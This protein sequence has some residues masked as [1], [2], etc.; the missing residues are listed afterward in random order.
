MIFNFFYLNLLNR[1][2]YMLNEYNKEEL[3]KIFGYQFRNMKEESKLKRLIRPKI[4]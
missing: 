4:N 3:D 1:R 2:N